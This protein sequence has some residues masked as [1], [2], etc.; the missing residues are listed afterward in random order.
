MTAIWVAT[1]IFAVT[2]LAITADWAHHT[3]VAWIGAV[4][5]VAAGLFMG[6]YSQE[7]ALA[8]IDFNTLG[9]LL[10]MML[11][12]V[13]LSKT[14]VFEYLAIQAGQRSG[15]DPWRLF[16]LLGGL[17]AVVSMFL[18]NLTVI[19]LVAP[20]TLLIADRLGI[21]PVPLIMGEAMLS[22]IG[23]TATLI[24]DPPN[25][26][27]ASAA[28]FTFNHFLW[29]LLPIV[30][31][32]YLP[33]LWTIR[34]VFAE[35]FRQRSSQLNALNA[36]RPADSIKD[37]AAL[38]KLLLVLG[39]V[40][41]LFVLQGTWALTPWYV[42]F[43]GVGLAMAWVRPNPEEILKEIEWSTLLFFTCLFVIVGG[44]EAAGVMKLAA[45]TLK[46]FAG[47]QLLLT[48]VLFIWIS[49]FLSAI[50]DNIPFV[51]AMIPILKNLG[52]EGLP[53]EPL[54]WALALGAGFGGNGTPIGASANIL[55]IA[56]SKQAGRPITFR[57]WV[58][59]GA[60]VTLMSCS[61]GTVVFLVIFG[62][63][64]N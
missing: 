30:I 41:G 43:L 47:S 26:M 49:A 58:K 27:I 36:L 12:M 6:F 51:V 44:L 54:W 11:L 50:V 24:G 32:A 16:L 18:N 9:L 42:A 28:G 25:T 23:G 13:M 46:D 55:A 52:A 63:I 7:Q 31:V 60:L 5:M 38:K 15:G 61:V 40:L 10:G 19:I 48:S 2:F 20:V 62:L 37:A 34:W 1:A 39:L 35:E 21:N 56:F 59:C 4:A 8:A 29:I 45:G 17:T 33:T 64:K 3:I 14:G 53:I 57:A 22:N